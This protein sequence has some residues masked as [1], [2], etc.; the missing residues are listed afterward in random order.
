MS[1]QETDEQ[2]N[3]SMLVSLTHWPMCHVCMTFIP[4]AGSQALS[5]FNESFQF[6]PLIYRMRVVLICCMSILTNGVHHFNLHWFPGL[7]PFY[8]LDC[9]FVFECIRESR[10]AC[11]DQRTILSHCLVQTSD[12]LILWNARVAGL[13]TFENLPVPPNSQQEH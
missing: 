7:F 2:S 1:H 9:C 10:Y 13:Q 3:G 8:L 11:R 12:F 5:L 4:S 6:L